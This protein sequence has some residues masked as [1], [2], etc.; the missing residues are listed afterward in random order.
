M[1]R[2]N[3]EASPASLKVKLKSYLKF[4]G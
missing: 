2:S 3:A 1:F 4:R